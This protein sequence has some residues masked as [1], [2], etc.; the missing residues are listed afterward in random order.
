MET[1]AM[2][3]API[4]ERTLFVSGVT[5]TGGYINAYTFQTRGGLLNSMHTGNMAK[6]GIYLTL[7]DW[8][9]LLSALYPI[10]ACLLGVVCSE[11][12]KHGHKAL[13]KK[14]LLAGDWRKLALLFQAV[15]LFC[16]GLVPVS[17]ANATVALLCSFIT[18]FQLN[19]FRSWLGIVHNSTICTGNIRT[20][21]QY[22]FEAVQLHNKP[23]IKRF[24]VHTGVVFSFVLDSAAGVGFS[25][26]LG[27]R[28]IWLCCAM[29][30]VWIMLIKRYEHHESLSVQA[31]GNT[32]SVA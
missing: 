16:I 2:K 25:L 8:G 5:F 11:C 4:W 21:G 17:V 18:G 24:F 13:V 27:I 14:G 26:L 6:V 7:G 9:N 30:L 29:L 10:L 22:L 1:K 32:S 19:L 3:K 23:S 31:V 28:S 12:I 15:F 20:M